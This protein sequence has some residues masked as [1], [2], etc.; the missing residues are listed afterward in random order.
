MVFPD[1]GGG[2]PAKTAFDNVP[3]PTATATVTP[4][5]GPDRPTR[6]SP[7]VTPRPDELPK[8]GIPWYLDLDLFDFVTKTLNIPVGPFRIRLNEDNEPLGGIELAPGA[9]PPPPKG[10]PVGPKPPGR[11]L[12]DTVEETI[13]DKF[14]VETG[15]APTDDEVVMLMVAAGYQPR[16]VG[17]FPQQPD[18]TARPRRLTADDQILTDPNEITLRQA[19][20]LTE[21]AR[22]GGPSIL[23]R[24]TG[25]DFLTLPQGSPLAEAGQRIKGGIKSTLRQTFPTDE[26]LAADAAAGIGGK[27]RAIG[28]LFS[29]GEAF[30]GFDL[31]TGFFLTEPLGEAAEQL[32]ASAS[33]Q[34]KIRG[35][36]TREAVGTV[37]NL[38]L[39]IIGWPRAPLTALRALRFGVRDVPRISKIGIKA[40]AGE[41]LTKL[42]EVAT[43]EKA[44]LIEQYEDDL[45]EGFAESVGASI[46]KEKN[47]ERLFRFARDPEELRNA[48]DSMRRGGGPPQK[49]QVYEDL[50]DQMDAVQ[51]IVTDLP[52]GG[53]LD[54]LEWLATRRVKGAPKVV[55]NRLKQAA[56]DVGVKITDDAGKL[57]PPKHIYDEIVGATGDLAI[58]PGLQFWPRVA[59]FS[60][61]EWGRMISRAVQL[62]K[63]ISAYETIKEHAKI[64]R[65]AAGRTPSETVE[66][67]RTIDDF[68]DSLEGLG[69]TDEAE[70]FLRNL[71]GKNP[72]VKI[73]D[74]IRRVAKDHGIQVEDSMTAQDVGSALS[75]K[76]GELSAPSPQRAAAAAKAA[77]IEDVEALTVE[78]IISE[79]TKRRRDLMAVNRAEITA[80]GPAIPLAS[81]VNALNNAELPPDMQL[82]IWRLLRFQLPG[83][84][85]T[86]R[87]T[88]IIRRT[89]GEVIEEAPNVA[90]IRQGAE[91]LV[92][93]FIFDDAARAR[94]MPAIVESLEVAGSNREK[95]ARELATRF[96][97]VF[98]GKLPIEGVQFR[99]MADQLAKWYGK[100]VKRLARHD[101][102]VTDTNRLV[103]TSSKG[104]IREL[105]NDQ[106]F[107][108]NTRVVFGDS[109]RLVDELKRAADIPSDLGAVQGISPQERV[110]QLIASVRKVKIPELQT[111]LRG[112]TRGL[113]K[114]TKKAVKEANTRLRP[115]RLELDKLEADIAATRDLNIRFQEELSRAMSTADEAALNADPDLAR[116]QVALAEVERTEQALEIL[117]RRMKLVGFGR[118]QLSLADEEMLEAFRRLTNPEEVVLAASVDPR[119][120]ELA[121]L[122]PQR[123]RSALVRLF[124][125]M[126][127]DE[128]R[129]A[130]EQLAGRSR[131]PYIGPLIKHVTGR[132]SNNPLVL[133]IFWQYQVG[134]AMGG[135]VTTAHMGNIYRLA[136]QL[137]PRKG[138]L[139]RLLDSERLE[140]NLAA[141][142]VDNAANRKA[143]GLEAN[144]SAAENEVVDLYKRQLFAYLRNPELYPEIGDDFEGL[145]RVYKAL[146]DDT[147]AAA[148]AMEVRPKLELEAA[149]ES[150]LSKELRAH[151]TDANL[152]SGIA[153]TWVSI[154]DKLATDPRWAN[155][156]LKDVV[157]QGQS[158]LIDFQE[159][160]YRHVLNRA[161]VESIADL[162]VGTSSV[163]RVYEN[164]NDIEKL[165]VVREAQKKARASVGQV[166]N[167]WSISGL[168]DWP[169]EMQGE[170]RALMGALTGPQAATGILG[171]AQDVFRNV[172]MW[173]LVMD[174]SIFG[175]QG[176][177]Y[178][179]M[180]GFLRPG[181]VNEPIQM[182]DAFRMIDD[183]HF[184]QWV[185]ANQDELMSYFSNGLEVGL[186]TLVGT[187]T[188]K[189][190]LIE[191]I[192][193]LLSRMPGAAGKL[194]ETATM[195]LGLIGRGA[196]VFNDIM[197]D[198]WM[199]WM[200]TNLIRQHLDGIQMIRASKAGLR[201]TVDDMVGARGETGGGLISFG[202]EKL[203]DDQIRFA[204]LPERTPAVQEFSGG[205][206]PQTG[207]GLMLNDGRVFG[208][209]GTSIESHADLA[210]FAN[211]PLEALQ[212]GG[213]IRLRSTS[214]AGKFNL[215]I[216][217]KAAPTPSQRN[218][219]GS[220]AEAATSVDI[221]IPSRTMREAFKGDAGALLAAPSRGSM[222]QFLDRTF[223]PTG[224]AGG[225]PLTGFGKLADELGGVEQLYLSSPEDTLRAVIRVV[226]QQLGGLPRSQTALGL[227][228]ET[229]ESFILFVPGF[230]RARLGLLN[231]ALTKPFSVEG[232][233]ALS[234]VARE[235]AFWGALGAFVSWRTGNLDKFNYTD[236]RRADFLAMQFGADWVPT[237]PSA[238][239]STRILARLIGGM[240]DIKDPNERL[241]ALQIL[242][243]GRLHPIVQSAYESM[244]GEDFLGNKLRGKQERF[245]NWAK[246]LQP[247][248]AEQMQETIERD[249]P[250]SRSDFVEIATK[251]LAE[252]M[253]KNII[254]R[255]PLEH[256]DEAAGN[257][258]GPNGELGRRWFELGP[259]EHGELLGQ[260]P[261]LE[262]HLADY[263]DNQL[264]RSSDKELRQTARF[265]FFEAAAQDTNIALSSLGEQL[266]GG[267]IDDDDF[268]DGRRKA[269]DV[270]SGAFQRTEDNMLADGF[271]PEE[272]FEKRREG[273]DKLG[274]IDQA[275]LDYRNVKFEDFETAQV[276]PTPTGPIEVT[277]PDFDGFDAARLAA[278][279]P[280]TPGVQADALAFIRQDEP[281]IETRFRKATQALDTYFATPKYTGM[282][283]KEG[284]LLDTF[285]GT[286]AEAGSRIRTQAGVQEVDPTTAIQTRILVTAQ[287]LKT[288]Q[289]KT[290]RERKILALA[291]TIARKPEL[292]TRIINPVKARIVL[293][294]PDLSLFYGFTA[295]DVP[296]EMRH[297]LP[298]SV[299][300][301]FT[302]T[303]GESLQGRLKFIE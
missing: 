109:E 139:G 161:T 154:A 156:S 267:V 288:G 141:N 191:H 84:D 37:A 157:K 103:F 78:Q 235:H 77:G 96:S 9:K 53:Q 233:L 247:I 182:F 173:R 12:F 231:A 68:L 102:G 199:L 183:E 117:Q 163:L 4:L 201:A 260:N 217:V 113:P 297:L 184:V 249:P 186:E 6:F 180:R 198:R 168:E 71:E 226:N 39:P 94:A 51:G 115:A 220:M 57:R 134:R 44:R 122:A 61:T 17:L 185:F 248:F 246:Q 121:A 172:M 252:F 237:I 225:G 239:S 64:R 11:E 85:E 8:D 149:R 120:R 238:A 188:N 36:I 279:S 241:R 54:T 258:R 111:Q 14:M 152:Q 116:R 212:G 41:Q 194:G 222:R 24:A 151:P 187:A 174:A 169:R 105:A 268:R 242:V 285:L 292:K 18:A 30:R 132:F 128:L 175:I 293:N 272:A 202:A 245:L 274:L 7:T 290:D 133:G 181:V 253:G 108:T 93:G 259:V 46:T 216:E 86:A 100:N 143:L 20:S 215:F 227:W 136:K 205:T 153:R 155:K 264:D 89:G 118:E 162:N 251:G 138:G 123:T 142:F 219:L 223:G 302:Q 101:I 33:L 291:L 91:E 131:L 234:A 218:A 35:P 298:F 278:L 286:F 49:A 273:K 200:K 176:S 167:Q 287:L 74:R 158:L 81:L 228:R 127:P 82:D 1:F 58:D 43:A 165:R 146:D 144:F 140:A 16:S 73:T 10:P 15:R 171:T 38:L 213:A 130:G 70:L 255:N 301:R 147:T 179:A 95:L 208:A 170:L 230:W 190:L 256:L 21:A 66:S 59:F 280:Y 289:V 76:R 221:E 266:D 145:A 189:P 3:K 240:N 193:E 23:S 265:D 276:V 126:Q 277:L 275:V 137:S 129:P 148:V 214:R 195:P 13:I 207:M 232:Q 284:A 90:N 166:N 250:T 125:I 27:E 87:L 257:K 135:L 107:L 62:R 52:T 177:F 299:Q 229:A 88:N 65:L 75:A 32:G 79:V 72:P 197:F 203:P 263:E 192:P 119:V 159:A 210:R 209:S 295:N 282:T 67:L 106:V 270:Q 244:R 243:G 300:Q 34:G 150:L 5:R 110:K 164:T 22:E 69:I 29:A 31:S 60:Q 80:G 204:A 296:D 283:A 294:N 99:H 56:N 211:T 114:P 236:P 104:V 261:A 97:A 47:R 26:Q 271:D 124:K 55:N 206:F 48:A 28:T 112:R 19:L 281:Q 196:R 160:K 25:L 98:S 262:Q 254:P 303:F 224:E 50:A 269:F 178:T 83:D 40:Y 42:S 63:Q 92:S 2:G 45:I